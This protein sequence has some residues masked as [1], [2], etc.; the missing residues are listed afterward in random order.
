MTGGLGDLRRV[1]GGTDVGWGRP[2]RCELSCPKCLPHQ[3]I[4]A[5]QFEILDCYYA[6]PLRGLLPEPQLSCGELAQHALQLFMSANGNTFP[7]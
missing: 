6:A 2:A 1:S 3:G 4:W 5:V 7:G